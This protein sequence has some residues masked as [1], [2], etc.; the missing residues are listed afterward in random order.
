MSPLT[1]KAFLLE[2]IDELARRLG[3]TALKDP[4]DCGE[5]TTALPDATAVL[6]VKFFHAMI[7]N[8]DWLLGPPETHGCGDI[9]NTEV[10]IHPDGAITL[11]PA[12]FDL[13]AMVVGEIR[14]PD[15]NQV[16]A[17]EV[18][19]AAAAASAA[20]ETRRSPESQRRPSRR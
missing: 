11:V 5:H 10:L 15:T 1:R 14:N 7:G 4:V 6:R 12:D 9:M 3:A 19:N 17:I 13:A 20:L 2:H 18:E 16:E 8:W